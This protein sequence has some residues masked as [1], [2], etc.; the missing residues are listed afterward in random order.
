[1]AQMHENKAFVLRVTKGYS[2]VAVWQWA[3]F[4]I[5]LLLIWVN[6]LL[7]IPSLLYD[8]PEREPDV[9]RGCVASA[10]V[11]ITGIITVGNTYLQQRRI[12]KGMLAVCSYC[13]KIRIEESAWEE[14]ESLL[15]DH[16]T[17]ALTHS[18]CPEC[19]EK[20]MNALIRSG[21]DKDTAESAKT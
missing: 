6:E 12:V 17:I 11:L 3:A 15:S 14:L 16:S 19:Y 21:D 13:R 4:V 2:Y 9:V 1:M 10:G 7:D 8:V 18:I 5:L 20:E